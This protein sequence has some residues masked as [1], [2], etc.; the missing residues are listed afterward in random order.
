MRRGYMI[1]TSI[2]QDIATRAGGDIYAG[3]VGPVRTGK[4]TFIKR[5]MDVLVFPNMAN[6]YEKTR[7][8]DELP[9]S[10]EGKTI[11]TTEPKFIPP[12]AVRVNTKGG[13]GFNVR[14]VD[15]VG[16]LVPG[17][18]GNMEDGK[19]RMVTTPWFEEQV[20]FSKA[21][22]VGTEKVIK[23]HSVIGIVVTTDGSF[24]ELPRNSF[25]EAE[26]KTVGQ[27]KELH[28]PFII[29]LNSA[30]PQS[31]K[32]K[33]LAA[34][35]EAKYQVPVL[36]ANCQKMSEENFDE[37]FEKLIY[38]FPAS[39]IRFDLPGYLDALPEDH[40][41][42]AT[43]I[44]SVRNWMD[45]FENIG[46]VMESC[47]DIADG[48]VVRSAKISWADMSKG[49]V[50]IEPKLEPS[51]YYKV[52]EE[53]MDAPVSGDRQ[54]F[55]LLREYTE[56]KRAYD[57]IKGA[58]EQAQTTDYGIVAPKLSEMALEKPEVFRQ[59]NKYGVRMKAKA[60]CLHIIRTDI[61]TEVSPLVGTESQSAELA[62]SLTDQFEK[63]GNEIWDTNL[64]G[65]SLREM[66]TEQME[67]KVNDM[68]ES[69]RGKIQRSLQKISDDGK[70]YFI[71]II[72]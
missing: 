33:E 5:F 50:S 47:N 55:T 37:L 66:V 25:L 15:C 12:E 39:E 17:A 58:I 23:D 70:D 4:S 61:S 34:E 44:E 29:I 20:P 18:L 67:S 16:Y 11:T 62:D 7:V 24:G 41:I 9:Q 64:F 28:R 21:A 38:Q 48:R 51:L 54:L 59:G 52:I 30:T 2:Y 27:L 63:G 69:L 43:M 26:E 22:E 72:L 32:S 35:L 68:P 46:Q 8:M 40:W 31:A 1:S 14:L 45:G 36:L 6:P 56:A 60:P 71:C 57:N 42:K 13:A 10:G 19:E 3:V 49:I 65:K 53:L